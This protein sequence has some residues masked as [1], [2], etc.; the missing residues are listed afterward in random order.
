MVQSNCLQ[1][2]PFARCLGQRLRFS[3]VKPKFHV[4]RRCHAT[5]PAKA[6]NETILS[7]SSL[8]GLC[9]PRRKPGL[10]RPSLLAL[11]RTAIPFACK[12][13]FRSRK[14]RKMT[15]SI[16]ARLQ[17]YSSM[18]SSLSCQQDQPNLTSSYRPTTQTKAP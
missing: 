9:N 10:L 13:Q 14:C 11:E 8:K 15:N 1:C 7:K 17:R 3:G 12:V 5:I 16:A 4:L 6:L 18:I 2:V